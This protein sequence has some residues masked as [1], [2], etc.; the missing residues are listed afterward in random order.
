MTVFA[1]LPGLSDSQDAFAI[2]VT[3]FLP[4][5]IRGIVLAAAMA[6]TMSVASGTILA[7][8]TIMYS[9]LYQRFVPHKATEKDE[10]R[11]TR[12]IAALIGIIVMICALWI[13]EV[14]VGVDICYGYLSGCVF[15]PVV[16]SFVLKRFSPK[17]G[18]WALAVSSVAVTVGFI[19]WGTASSIPIVIGM[20][21][22]LIAYVA[23][24]LLDPT[25]QSSPL[26]NL[27]EGNRS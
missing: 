6:A 17:A 9:D 19:V 7:S 18:L 21:S 27:D 8:S 24:M 16:A 22:G 11:V 3:T 1:L 26:A 25:R 23:A 20:L 2:G 4:A 12:L 10:I 5:G 15:V 13:K 14:L